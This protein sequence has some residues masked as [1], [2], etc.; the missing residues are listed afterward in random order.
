MNE[1]EIKE[2]KKAVLKRWEL[3]T[4]NNLMGMIE[5]VN[6]QRPKLKIEL[7]E[8]KYSSFDLSPSIPSINII[9]DEAWLAFTEA[10]S[11]TDMNFWH[12]AEL[13]EAACNAL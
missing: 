8:K 5:V 12:T 13:E 9:K 11:E 6:N 4:G 3:S 10:Y 7:A 1:T 2:L